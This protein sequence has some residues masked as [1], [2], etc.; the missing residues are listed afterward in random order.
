[1]IMLVFGW[2]VSVALFYALVNSLGNVTTDGHSFSYEAGHLRGII[3]ARENG[4]QEQDEIEASATASYLI[5]RR[6]MEVDLIEYSAGY[7]AGYAMYLNGF[8]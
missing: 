4:V 3:E 1:M 6:S 7:V 8:I 5:A 2:L